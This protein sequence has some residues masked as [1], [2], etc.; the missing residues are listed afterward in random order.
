MREIG[1]NGAGIVR[2]MKSHREIYIFR[3]QDALDV[4]E[5]R[6]RRKLLVI[7]RASMAGIWLLC[8]ESQ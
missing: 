7:F 8:C 4:E 6:E 2:N 1:K 5:R 3:H